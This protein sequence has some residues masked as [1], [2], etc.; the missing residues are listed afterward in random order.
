MQEQLLFVGIM[1]YILHD[2]VLYSTVTNNEINS[3]LSTLLRTFM[4]KSLWA[5]D[6][7][8]YS[9]KISSFMYY[10]FDIIKEIQCDL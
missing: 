7:N 9:M 10:Y 6:R 3:L 5:S 1:L 8:A 4:F 2:I